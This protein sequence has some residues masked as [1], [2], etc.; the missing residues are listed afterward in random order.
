[1][2]DAPTLTTGFGVTTRRIADALHAAGRQ[3]ACFGFK[4]TPDDVDGTPYPVWAAERGDHWT[5]SLPDFL[6]AHR[7]DLV[8]LNMDAFNAVECLDAA[9]AAGW[10]GPVLSYVVFDGLPVTG[11]YLAAQRSCTAVLASSQ[12]AAAY[13]RNNGVAV[14]DV[15]PPG[16][17]PT[18]FAPAAD[19]SALRARAGVADAAVVGVFGT[20]TERKQ[21]A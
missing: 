11:R 14:V 17:D 7:P 5:R 6:A 2:S 16:V 19:R 18:V 20:N 12:T 21:I 15:A 10:H 1:M 9:C 8:L 3:V 4:A 13:L